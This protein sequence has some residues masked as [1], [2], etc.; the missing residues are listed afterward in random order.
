MGKLILIHRAARTPH[1]RGNQQKNKE[2]MGFYALF[3]FFAADLSAG[4][5]FAAAAA[6]LFFLDV[7]I[8]SFHG[9]CGTVAT[10]W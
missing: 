1:M 7:V 3:A 9:S 8:T 6:L 10:Y 5:F 2:K 4:A